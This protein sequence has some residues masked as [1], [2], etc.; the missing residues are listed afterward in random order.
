MKLNKWSPSYLFYGNLVF[1]RQSGPRRHAS[2]ALLRP[3]RILHWKFS[4]S[5]HT[6]HQFKPL[7]KRV[8]QGQRQRVDVSENDV[9]W[10]RELFHVGFDFW[11]FSRAKYRHSDVKHGVLVGRVVKNHEDHEY[12]GLSCYSNGFLYS[13]QGETQSRVIILILIFL[14]FM[15]IIIIAIKSEYFEKLQTKYKINH[16]PFRIS[17]GFRKCLYSVKYLQT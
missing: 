5:I 11:Q 9:K 14:S 1:W 7:P 2:F 6:R 13:L 10:K 15:L 12:A 17:E 4:L 3:S 16:V 8:T